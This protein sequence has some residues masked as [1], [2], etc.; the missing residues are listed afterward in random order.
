MGDQSGTEQFGIRFNHVMFQLRQSEVNLWCMLES[1][2][3]YIPKN[4]KNN[5]GI[6]S[7]IL[8]KQ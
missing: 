4:L 2:S 3:G 6:S 7:D 8:P 1:F 5:K